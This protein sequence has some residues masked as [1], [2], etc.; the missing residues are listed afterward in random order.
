MGWT[1]TMMQAR[2]EQLGRDGAWAFWGLVTFALALPPSALF[3]LLPGAESHD[4]PWVAAVTAWS[5]LVVLV[6]CVAGFYVARFYLRR[7]ELIRMLDE[8]EE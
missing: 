2:Y 8:Y 3:A 6:F 7:A 1:A 4:A 5:T